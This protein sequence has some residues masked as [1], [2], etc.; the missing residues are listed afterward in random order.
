MLHRDIVRALTTLRP[1]SLWNL[2]GDAYSG[3]EWLDTNSTCPS[4]GDILAAI[5]S[6]VPPLSLQ[7]QITLLKQQILALQGH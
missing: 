3:I 6:Y 1:G 4:E 5:A 2:N 7:D